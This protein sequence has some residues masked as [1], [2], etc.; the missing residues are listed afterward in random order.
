MGKTTIEVPSHKFEAGDIS[1]GIS[2]LHPNSN[3]NKKKAFNLPVVWSAFLFY[4]CYNACDLVQ[5]QVYCN[6]AWC[7]ANLLVAFPTNS[8]ALEG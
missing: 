4:A 5:L 7:F 6:A 2:S 1:K 3:P 8:D